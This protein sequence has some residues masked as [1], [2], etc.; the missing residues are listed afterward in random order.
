MTIGSHTF[1]HPEL[2]RQTEESARREIVDFRRELEMCTQTTVWAFAYPF[3]NPSAV[4]QRELQLVQEAGYNCAFMNM[5]GTVA[6]TGRFILPRV[7][8]SADMNLGV[9]E[10]HATGFHHDLQRWFRPT[11]DGNGMS[12]LEPADTRS[13]QVGGHETAPDVE[14]ND[15]FPVPLPLLERR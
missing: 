12:I 8:V 2:S 15:S 10:A 1:S 4:G 11:Q 5:L 7:H 9:L 3:G 6:A 14:R 13:R